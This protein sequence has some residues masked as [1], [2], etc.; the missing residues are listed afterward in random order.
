MTEA[1]ITVEDYQIPNTESIIKI[2]N[3]S[4]QL[5]ESNIDEKIKSIYDVIEK[6]PNSLKLL[7][8]L[9]NL[10]YMNS[11]SIGYLTDIYGKVMKGSGVMVIS[12][13]KPN[14]TDILQV[15]GL[16]QLVKTFPTID[17]AKIYL[18]SHSAAQ[19]LA[20][21]ETP[22]PPATPAS[23]APVLDVQEAP[24]P[25]PNPA[26]DVQEAP[27]P[28]PNTASDMQEAPAPTP[29]P[30]SD[31]QEAPA[32]TPTPASDMQEAP[33]P[34]PTP[35]SDMQEAPAPTPTPVS[36]IQEAPAPTPTPVSEVQEVSNA[37]ERLDK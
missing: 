17:E 32:P 10:D 30:V 23:P 11:K 33:A 34:T 3:I 1:Q 12:N 27:A 5:D 21:P 20:E 24:A 15:V 9:G 36:D 6:V 26:S 29:T 18:G 4:G 14:I 2:A 13:A 19:V 25:T 28:T 7:L 8:N 22:V 31:M 35:A 16:T 37:E